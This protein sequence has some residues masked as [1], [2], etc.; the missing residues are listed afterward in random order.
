MS[1]RGASSQHVKGIGTQQCFCDASAQEAIEMDTVTKIIQEP[2][3]MPPAVPP[4]SI[5]MTLSKQMGR[6]L[7]PAENCPTQKQLAGAEAY[8]RV[9]HPS[10]GL[11]AGA[12][13][14]A[15]ERPP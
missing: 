14:P 12:L 9:R 2:A 4:A 10:T 3:G 5:S 15:P 7:V 13:R 8:A 6:V 1:A 11:L